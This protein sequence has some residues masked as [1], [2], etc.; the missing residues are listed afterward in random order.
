VAALPISDFPWLTAVL[1]EKC[2]ALDREW[3]RRNI[4]M[5]NLKRPLRMILLWLVATL[6]AGF[7]QPA[8]A[9]GYV[10]FNGGNGGASHAVSGGF[11]MGKF[12]PK[13]DPRFLLG[14]D[15]SVA[16]NGYPGERSQ[17]FQSDIRN[18]Q[19]IGVVAGIRLAK[20]FYAVGTGGASSRDE[21]DYLV[22]NGKRILLAQVPGKVHGSGSGQVRFVYKRLIFGAGYHS[23]R[24]LV[25]GVGFTFSG[26]TPRRESLRR[27]P[28]TLPRARDEGIAALAPG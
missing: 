23:R 10:M 27:E 4:M 7:P 5:S 15:F 2:G 28:S 3:D 22:A 17:F 19:Q 21:R 8:R 25:V 20:G 26:F 18:E 1:P 12:F 13:K 24:G 14:G 16:G 11:E 9:Q 6:G